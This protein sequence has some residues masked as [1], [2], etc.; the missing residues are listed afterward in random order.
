MASE[1]KMSEA[2]QAED[3]TE[4]SA[5]MK[6]LALGSAACRILD[7][8]FSQQASAANLCLAIDTDLCCLENLS[9]GLPKY[10]FGQKIFR[11]LNAG[12]DEALVKDSLGDQDNIIQSFCQKSDI[13][14]ILVGLSG[15][16]GSG[17]LLSTVRVAMQSG[18][19]T[20]VVPIFPFSFEG[21][22]KSIRAQTWIQ[23]LRSTADLVIPFYNDHLFQTLPESAT[24]KEAFAY[25]N[26]LLCQL[27]Q[28]L[29]DS[30]TKAENSAF[31][32]HLGDF[33]QHFSSKPDTVFWGVGE[34]SGQNCVEQALRK[35][36]ENISIK[37]EWS[38]LS[39][40]PHVFIFTQLTPDIAL[41]ELKNLNYEI[42][43]FL[44]VPQ[45]ELLNNCHAHLPG[46]QR[47]KIFLFV[48]SMKKNLKA[49]RYAHKAASNV[50]LSNIQIQF[51]FEDQNQDSYWDT[52]TYLRLGLK[53]EP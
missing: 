1:A 21:K 50:T 45:I 23:S 39:P 29:F 17:L 13:L 35:T 41:L 9:P 43:R 34:A 7:A 30:L 32:C 6:F 42:Q 40:A 22:T 47:A 53:L 20:V 49:S 27:L 5:R 15:G 26:T 28:S 24:I 44:G 48:T 19:F 51:D 14:V 3:R 25:G 2:F 31:V 36:F 12:G 11:G 4:S 18:I 38:S 16:T 33:I 8:F 37:M 46:E 10:C 52:P